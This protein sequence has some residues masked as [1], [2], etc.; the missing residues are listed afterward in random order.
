MVA[1]LLRSICSVHHSFVL[2]LRPAGQNGSST[3]PKRPQYSRSAMPRI[4]EVSLQFVSTFRASALTSGCVHK[5]PRW[6]GVLAS[7]E[8]MLLYFATSW[9][10]QSLVSQYNLFR[11]VHKSK[12]EVA[13]APWTRISLHWMKTSD[14]PSSGKRSPRKKGWF[15][16]LPRPRLSDHAR[17]VG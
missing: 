16:H 8:S 4:T 10:I 7:I 11:T 15:Y 9:T 5:M 13:E 3:Q 6:E 2:K 14:M 1:C 12:T 17:L